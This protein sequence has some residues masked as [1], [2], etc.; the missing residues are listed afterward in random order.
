[1]IDVK[2][3]V[4]KIYKVLED[5]KASDIKILY[6][7]DLTV[8]ADYFIIATGNSDTHVKALTEE[9]EK[10]LMEEGILVDHIEGYNWGKW[11]LMDYGDVIVHIFQQIEREFY[12]L[13]RLWADAKEIV[14]DNLV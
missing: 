14:L 8:V 7:G 10:K 2:D 13:E 3:K 6:I 4:F 12:N 1:M 9:I 5:N 11:V